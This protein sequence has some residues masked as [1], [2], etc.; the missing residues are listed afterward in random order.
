MDLS[1]F[2]ISVFC[3]IDDRLKKEERRLR[4]C[5]PA[6]KLSDAAVLTIEVV[7]EFLGIDT[8]KGIYRY[9]RR[10]YGEW[11]PALREVHRTT[12]CRQAGLTSGP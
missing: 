6:P 2:I 7:G 11:F 5:G 12:F 9:F 1:T 8:D 10:H 3:L 4:K